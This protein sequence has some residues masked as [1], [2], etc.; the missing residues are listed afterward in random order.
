MTANVGIAERSDRLVITLVAT[1][2]VGLGLP[3]ALLLVVLTLLAAASV[4]TVF[5]RVLTVRRQ[6]P[7]SDGADGVHSDIHHQ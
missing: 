4:V 7:G 1:G 6:A 3:A 5:Q 2:L